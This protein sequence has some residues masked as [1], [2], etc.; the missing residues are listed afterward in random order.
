MNDPYDFLIYGTNL[1]QCIIASVLAKKG[2]RVCQIDDEMLYGAYDG[3]FSLYEILEMFNTQNN[4]NSIIRSM[5]GIDS[6]DFSI[7]FANDAEKRQIMKRGRRYLIDFHPHIPF[8]NSIFLK[9]IIKAK[10]QHYLTFKF[11]KTTYIK[12][13]VPTT[14]NFSDK[15][16]KST[17]ITDKYV[18]MP[19][20]K[21]D[22]FSS[23]SLSPYDK[24]FV[25]KFIMK[26]LP[27]AKAYRG[28]EEAR[29]SSLAHQDTSTLSRKDVNDGAAML[30][31]LNK[32]LSE[33][34]E[35]DSLMAESLQSFVSRLGLKDTFWLCSPLLRGLSHSLTA[36]E[37]QKASD[38]IFRCVT[39]LSGVGVYS[40]SCTLSTNWGSG[41]YPQAFAR[42]GAVN[43]CSYR[44]CCHILSI[45]KIRK[46]IIL[47]KSEDDQV[48]GSKEKK[49]ED[50]L[51]YHVSGPSDEI[52]MINE[53]G[54]HGDLE[55]REEEELVTDEEEER[56]EE[57]EL[58]CLSC[59]DDMPNIE[60]RHIILPH[61]RA[62]LEKTGMSVPSLW[63]VNLIVKLSS[64]EKKKEDT[65]HSSSSSCASQP[66]SIPFSLDSLPLLF[67]SPGCYVIVRGKRESMCENGY[68]MLDGWG[69]NRD[70]VLTE[71]RLICTRMGEENIVCTI[72]FKL[73]PGQGKP[74]IIPEKEP[75][76]GKDI[77]EQADSIHVIE[78]SAESPDSVRP[79]DQ[80]SPVEGSTSIVHEYPSIYE[81]CSQYP[82]QVIYSHNPMFS[83]A[84]TCGNGAMQE[85][86]RICS[87]IGHS[88]PIDSLFDSDDWKKGDIQQAEQICGKDDSCSDEKESQKVEEID[89]HEKGRV[90]KVLDA[91]D[92]LDIDFLLEEEEKME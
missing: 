22:L 43:G 83:D 57:E 91:L 8:S 3:T 5:I 48:G 36:P 27:L 47:E 66:P 69:D 81:Q 51:T 4:E 14:A 56:G 62:S 20:T 44:L 61:T 85:C 25:M 42:Y 19:F 15:D 34:F 65:D 79:T 88:I 53:D 1:S 63:R 72:S 74:N 80:I 10:I 45:E 76:E 11:P 92:G 30:A 82:D 60:T 77:K 58:L 46:R 24:H 75:Q 26:L 59:A 35:D 28:N 39:A 64:T 49:E 31:I 12:S 41:E 6:G 54:S 52:V 73:D 7:S 18:P 2:Y 23:S 50:G 90:E 32:E 55:E 33:P 29:D 21:S 40:P 70:T 84:F 37:L 89:E 68:I 87:N 86:V 38:G 16:K 67:S 71:C 17:E 13:F 78:F 9:G